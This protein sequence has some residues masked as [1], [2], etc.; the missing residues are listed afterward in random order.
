MSKMKKVKRRANWNEYFLKIAALVA[1]R[2]TCKRHHIGAVIVKD[3]QILTTGY[4]GAA[5]NLPDCM[6]KGC[7]RDKL[8]IP[9]G[10][11]QQV[12]RAIHA[13]QN[14]I[15]QAAIHGQNISGSTLYC[16]HSPCVICAK[17]IVNARIKTVVSYDDY[18]GK[19]FV[20]LFKQA[21]IEFKKIPR[22]RQIIEMLD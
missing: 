9:S 17:M 10:Q 16:T 4:N 15:I 2:S 11:Q 14:A 21:G 13:E 6:Q 1:E 8:K 18:A 20:K 12:C 3:R 5:R 7:I 19:A 22:P